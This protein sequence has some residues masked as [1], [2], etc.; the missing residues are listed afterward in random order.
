MIIIDSIKSRLHRDLAANPVAHGWV[1]NLYLNGERYPQQVC[2]YFQSE[3]APTEEL[4]TEL[5]RHR[6]DEHKHELLYAKALRMLAQPVLQL[7]RHDIFNEVIR[8]FTPGTFHIVA[9]DSIGTRRE[10]LA[11]FLAHAHFLEKRVARSLCY[12]VE[13]CNDA[14][15][16]G[17]AELVSKV[18][19]DEER[20]VCYTRQ[21]VFDLLPRRRASEV[22]ALHQQAE[23]RANLFFSQ[24]ELRT[25]VRCFGNILPRTRRLLYRLCAYVM[26]GALRYV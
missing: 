14:R 21:S 20:H 11:N 15:S 10:K 12:H 24:H 23:A 22:L 1:L 25:F 13:A 19:C 5:N 7:P 16:Y 4:A 2:D 18:L 3:Y 17:V 26:E 6:R 8:S 9:T